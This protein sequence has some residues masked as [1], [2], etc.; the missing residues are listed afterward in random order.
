MEILL[1][2]NYCQNET[3]VTDFH[4]DKWFVSYFYE[5]IKINEI[6]KRIK[7]YYISKLILS[8]CVFLCIY[9]F[10]LARTNIFQDSKEFNILME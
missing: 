3:E 7:V 6:N 1:E 5:W 8:I 9:L 10:L 4:C 2:G